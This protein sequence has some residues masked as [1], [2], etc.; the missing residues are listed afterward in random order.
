MSR[1]ILLQ[2]CR[3]CS[4]P[5]GINRVGCFQGFF[6]L[7]DGRGSY[8]ESSTLAVELKMSCLAKW[9]LLAITVNAGLS[10][11]RELLGHSPLPPGRVR[12]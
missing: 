5:A 6:W 8:P 3:E 1:R 4:I 11:G 9:D 10:K 2:S 12:G 7:A